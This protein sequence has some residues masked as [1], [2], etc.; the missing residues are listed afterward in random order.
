MN[1][2]R[3]AQKSIDSSRKPTYY[4][5]LNHIAAAESLAVDIDCDELNEIEK[6]G[7]LVLEVTDDHP[8]FMTS[9]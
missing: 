6:I 1:S 5:L 7:K 8:I 4:L 3:E 2:D 9:T